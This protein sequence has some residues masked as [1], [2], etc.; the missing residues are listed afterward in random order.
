MDSKFINV[1]IIT[2]L[3]EKQQ[4]TLEN[5]TM[6]RASIYV[7]D[8]TKIDGEGDFPCPHC[9]AI[10]SPEDESESNYTI[11]DTKYQG[12]SL[13][14]LEELTIQCNNCKNKIRIVGFLTAENIEAT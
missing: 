11:L 4:Q 1:I 14:K 7:V 5:Q 3:Y 6:K 8:L 10:I 9:G 13:E 12:E 2:N